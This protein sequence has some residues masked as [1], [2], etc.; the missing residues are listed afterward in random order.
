[1]HGLFFA[2][3]ILFFHSGNG[4]LAPHL[5]RFF[6]SFVH[7][8]VRVGAH[9]WECGSVCECGGQRLPSE[10]SSIASPCI[11]LFPSVH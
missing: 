3:F 6:F 4:T 1:M 2:F 7:V 11:C 5:R 9:V 10:T 8:C